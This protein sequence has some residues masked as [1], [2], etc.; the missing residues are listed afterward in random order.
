MKSR[1][2]PPWLLIV[3]HVALAGLLC[4]LLLSVPLWVGERF[5]PKIP[6]VSFGALPDTV[7]WILFLFLFVFILLAFLRPF[8]PWT[9]ISIPSLL[10]VFFVFDQNRL[11]ASLYFYF[12]LFV[13]L[14]NASLLEMS[15]AQERQIRNTLRLCV[16]GVYLWSGLHKISIAFVA[17]MFP[18]FLE[19]LLPEKLINDF[20]VLGVFVP[21]LEAGFALCLWSL[22]WRRLGVVLALAMHLFILSSLGPLGHHYN[23]IVWPWNLV[24]C[25]LVTVLFFKSNDRDGLLEVLRSGIPRM[26]VIV[27]L[28]FLILPGLHLVG[29][30]DTYPSFS[31]YTPN[32]VPV[33]R[34]SEDVRVSFPPKLTPFLHPD[35]EGS[36]LYTISLIY[37]SE[38]ELGTPLYPEERVYLKV[39]RALCQRWPEAKTLELLLTPRPDRWTGEATT[40][41]ISCPES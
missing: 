38:D 12:A 33:L 19:P 5:F 40:K 21:F 22:R 3:H 6:I 39:F 14:A 24:M 41:V 2:Y 34:M 32:A 37:W 23:E 30:W 26:H 15:A 31:L 35:R 1:V 11:N 25:S 10:A 28:F 8:V 36:S 9:L 17:S 16:V 4:G 13:V 20:A 29:H 18:W 27:V 7:E